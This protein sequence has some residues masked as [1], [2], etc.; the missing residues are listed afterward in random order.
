MNPW[1]GRR[2]GAFIEPG[3]RIRSDDCG[4]DINEPD[5]SNVAPAAV[6]ATTALTF[7]LPAVVRVTA[8]DGLRVRRTPDASSRGNV[9]GRLSPHEEI[10]AFACEGEWLT[11]EYRG[12]RAYIHAAD[13]QRSAVAEF[14]LSLVAER[15]RLGPERARRAGKGRPSVGRAARARPQSRCASSAARSG[16]GPRSRTSSTARL[17]RA[18]PLRRAP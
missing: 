5:S 12:H 10:E 16:R 18:Q 15:T 17:G 1:P 7:Q 14:E 6:G 3:G 9:L 2:A 8:T 4:A 13:A 11:V